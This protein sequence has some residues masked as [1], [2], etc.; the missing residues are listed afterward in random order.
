LDHA[1]IGYIIIAVGLEKTFL[2]LV[3]FAAVHEAFPGYTIALGTG[4][5]DRGI[6]KMGDKGGQKIFFYLYIVVQKKKDIM[7][8]SFST[9][10]A[11]HGEPPGAV[12]PDDLDRRYAQGKINAIIGA[13][14]VGDNNLCFAAIS[15]AGLNNRRQE[16]LQ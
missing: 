1:C 16:A 3:N 2:E 9:V 6:G 11:C 13:V 12:P 7:P 5:K 4:G 15:I 10:V 8:C 14:I